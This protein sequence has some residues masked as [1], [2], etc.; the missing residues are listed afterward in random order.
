[1]Q[2]YDDMEEKGLLSAI[3]LE[4]DECQLVRLVESATYSCKSTRTFSANRP[5]VLEE[6]VV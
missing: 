5:I 6:P 1:M 4:I 2:N 3:A